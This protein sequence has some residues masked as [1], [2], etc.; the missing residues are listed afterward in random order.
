MNFGWRV[1]RFSFQ[2]FQFSP[3]DSLSLSL[4]VS[5][6]TT[7]ELNSTTPRRTH[8]VGSFGVRP[9]L[10]WAFWTGNICWGIPLDFSPQSIP[11]IRKMRKTT[12]PI[13]LPST[14]L[15]NNENIILVPSK[16][17]WP[18]I[19]LFVTLRLSLPAS[20][21]TFPFPNFPLRAV[22]KGAHKKNERKNVTKKDYYEKT[23]AKSK[24]WR[25]KLWKFSWEWYRGKSNLISRF[26]SSL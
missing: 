14:P 12:S 18:C 3:V 23:P 5:R 4:S 2:D 13:G 22:K 6:L 26:A 8:E 11:S 25:G 19:K 1:C 17:P 24:K 9:Q 15:H 21:F 20:T 16:N 7:T 10:L